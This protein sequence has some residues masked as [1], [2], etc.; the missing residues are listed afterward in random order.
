[1]RK[2]RVNC[3]PA[4]TYFA[5]QD[6]G[7][8]SERFSEPSLANFLAAVDCFYLLSPPLE[9]C[10]LGRSSTRCSCDALEIFP[11]DVLPE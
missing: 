11:G 10:F 2:Q 6:C 3:Y 5:V 4:S 1:M 7:D 8:V 9:I